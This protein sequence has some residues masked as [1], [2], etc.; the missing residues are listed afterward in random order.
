MFILTLG[1]VETHETRASFLSISFLEMAESD[2]D[3]FLDDEFYAN[4]GNYFDLAGLDEED[5]RNMNQL[6]NNLWADCDDA[7]S[8]HCTPL[9]YSCDTGATYDITVYIPDTWVK[10]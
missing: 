9:S 3:E 1:S 4:L 10:V 5:R 2:A 6:L 7:V 8:T